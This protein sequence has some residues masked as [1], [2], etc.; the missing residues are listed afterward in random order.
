MHLLCLGDSLTDCGRILSHPP[1]G[2]GYVHKVSQKLNQKSNDWKV[3]NCGVDGYTAGRLLESLRH[4]IIPHNADII[5]ILIGINDIGL[6]MNTN[7]TPAQQTNMM[8]DFLL[9]YENLAV[10]LTTDLHME[11]PA[12]T[13][14]GQNQNTHPPVPVRPIPRII[15]MEPF[16]LPWPARYANWIPHIRTMSQGISTLA[17]KHQYTYIPLHHRLNEEARKY[18]IPFISEDGVHLTPNGHEI[19]AQELFRSLFP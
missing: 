4:S 11:S 18:G 2:N 9:T 6:M 1:L 14:S 3:T 15:L 19:L 7:R 16:I 13:S 17:K 8:E 12:E 5:S 10:M